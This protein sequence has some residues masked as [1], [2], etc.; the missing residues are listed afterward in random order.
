M[1]DCFAEPVLGLAE[2]KARGLA[3]TVQLEQKAS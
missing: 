3:M 1:L 2:G